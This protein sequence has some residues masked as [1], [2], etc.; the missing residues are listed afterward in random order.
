MLNGLS[1]LYQLDEFIKILGLLGGIFI[2]MII[3]QPV[4]RHW[5]PDQT[6]SSAASDQVLPCLYL[7]HKKDAGCIWIKVKQPALV[8]SAR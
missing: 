2:Q 6:R 8:S 3:E 4:S 1:H 7:S 5:R